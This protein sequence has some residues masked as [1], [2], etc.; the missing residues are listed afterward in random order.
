MKFFTGCL[1]SAFFGGV[2]SVWMMEGFSSDIATAQDNRAYRGPF[3]RPQNN[4]GLKQPALPKL[5][6]GLSEEERINVSVYERVNKS[7]VNITTKSANGLFLIEGTS[8][9]AGSGCVID[10]SGHILTNFHVIRDANRVGV[11]LFDGKTYEA[12]LVGADPINDLAILK[13]QASQEKLFPVTLG[14]SGKLNVGMRVFAI[15]NPFGLERTMTTGIISSLNRSLKIRGNRTIRSIIQID[16]AVNPGNSGGPLLNSRGELI[17]INTAIASRTG[18]NSG[19]GF[20][21]PANL[22]SRVVPQLLKH[23][24]VIRPEIGIRRVYETEK[25]LLIA[26]LNPNGPAA[27]A[28]LRGPRITRTRRGIFIV[29]QIDRSAADFI[30]AIDGKRTK[31]ADDFLAAIEAKRPG[32]TVSLTLIREKR[33]ITVNVQ[34]GGNIPSTSR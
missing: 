2:L 6:V 14:N 32:D 17:G 33:S 11:T 9:G 13:I 16:A 22:I 19:I 29:E 1:I 25:G 3:L 5:P 34:L 4:P 18:Q 31:T 20:A 10:R 7:V 26:S 23:G 30:V 15:G 28:G 8:E 12:S 21:I 27:R 24:R